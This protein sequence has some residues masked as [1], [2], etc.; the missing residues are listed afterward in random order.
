MDDDALTRRVL[1]C[2][3]SVH[4]ELGTGYP[5]STYQHAVT[6]ELEK[7]N[8][9]FKVAEAIP[10]VYQGEVIDQVTVDFVI[11]RLIL[12]LA[13]K[14]ALEKYDVATSMAS[15]KASGL[16]RGLLVNFGG[17]ELEVRRL[18]NVPRPIV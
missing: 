1:A 14:T 18:S 17:K 9:V 4:Y 13:S 11:E 10:V 15:L 16:S 6:R 7:A 8:L 12:N 5:V 2:C 3:R